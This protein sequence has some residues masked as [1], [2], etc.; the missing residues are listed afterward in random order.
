L[1]LSREARRDAE[2]CE[3]YGSIRAV[4]HDVGWLDVLV[5]E[6]ALVNLA[7]SDARANRDVKEAFDF[8]R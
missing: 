3:P 6:T 2:T 5:D 4:R 7:E 8:Q 1:A